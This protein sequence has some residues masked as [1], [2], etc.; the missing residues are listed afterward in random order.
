MSRYN[1]KTTPKVRRGKV[2]RKDRTLLSPNYWNT[3]QPYPALDRRR[4]G[5]GYR[6]LILKKD[7]ECFIDMLPQWDEL[8]VGLQAVV[9]APGGKDCL[10]WH[11]DGVVGICAWERDLEWED[12]SPEFYEEHK[13]LLAKLEV[14]CTLARPNW[15]L[16]FDETTARAFQL[17]HV[18]V[19]ELGH[20]HDRMTTRSKTNSARGEPYAESYARRYEDEIIRRYMESPLW[21]Q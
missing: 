17:I 11:R 13:E 16:S 4:P 6:H 7:L 14:P 10:G 1:R 2:Q 18:F 3:P 8:S 9:L 12:A 5:D 20:H 15:H 19:H 21:I